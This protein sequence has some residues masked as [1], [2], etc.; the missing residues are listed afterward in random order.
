[1]SY[2]TTIASAKSRA[3]E[4]E[5]TMHRR[6]CLQCSRAAARD[7]CPT[8]DSLYQDRQ[9]AWIELRASRELDKQSITGQATLY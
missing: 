7:R 1:M 2:E 6:R 5:W 3:A 4:H 9:T 8:G